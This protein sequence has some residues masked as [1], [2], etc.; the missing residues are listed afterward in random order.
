MTPS[1]SGCPN[2]RVGRQCRGERVER[3]VSRGVFAGLLAFLLGG[4]LV[5][6]QPAFAGGS[7]LLVQ[8][9]GS[10]NPF[11]A[12]PPP[13]FSVP[14]ILPGT[15][16]AREVS[17]LNASGDTGSLSLRTQSVQERG[18]PVDGAGSYGCDT[19]GGFADQLA[20]Q[21]WGS[22]G[23]SRQ[24][25]YS[26]SVCDLEARPVL[27]EST[28]KAGSKADYTLTA[29]LPRSVGDDFMGASATWTFVWQLTAT[30]GSVIGSVH[31]A[32][33]SSAGQATAK[34]AH[35]GGVLAFTGSQPAALLAA[36]LA[37]V[38]VGVLLALAVRWAGGP[39]RRRA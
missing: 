12:K 13:V 31:L 37:A 1:R 9:G 26:G 29:Q 19:P 6:L 25:L 15:S 34:Q 33:H 16:L 10:T 20:V 28:L 3:I 27:L 23:S 22:V 36:G 35:A 30:A 17:A 32:A 7:G 39:I 4:L 24:E 8:V 11:T 38:L 5:G 21:V 2:G 18:G 14:S